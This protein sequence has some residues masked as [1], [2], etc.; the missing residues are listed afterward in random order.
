MCVRHHY[1]FG[2]RLFPFCHIICLFFSLFFSQGSVLSNCRFI[3]AVCL[4]IT[5]HGSLDERDEAN[6]TV[7]ILKRLRRTSTRCSSR[8]RSWPDLPR[9][10][11]RAGPLCPHRVCVTGPLCVALY[12]EDFSTSGPSHVTPSVWTTLFSPLYPYI[13]A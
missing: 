10:Q 12:T 9:L 1:I 5:L 13:S 6:V 7:F 11:P 8:G 4:Y 3:K 2:P